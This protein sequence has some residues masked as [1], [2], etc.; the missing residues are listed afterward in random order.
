VKQK[1]VKLPAV[2]NPNSL[3]PLVLVFLL[4]AIPLLVGFWRFPKFLG[5]EGIYVS[6]AWWWTHFKEMGPYTYWY[7]HFPLGWLQIGLWQKLTGGP[8]AFG[9]SLFSGRLFMILVS[10]LSSVFLF[11]LIHNVTKSVFIAL[12][13]VV[14]FAF[15][16]LAVLFHRQVLLD[17]LAS[18]WLLVSLFVFLREPSK[19]KNVFLGSVFLA[20]AVLSKES[21]LFVVPPFLYM[22]HVLNSKVNRRYQTLLALVTTGFLLSLFPLLA[23]LKGEFLPGGEHVSFVETLF[24]QVKRGSGLLFWKEGSDLCQK[25]DF[26]LQID[27]WLIGAGFGALVLNLLFQ[28]KNKVVIGLALMSVFFTFFLIRGGTILDFYIIPLL[29]LLVLQ[30][31]FLIHLLTFEARVNGFI[32]KHPLSWFL[33]LAVLTMFWLKEGEFLYLENATAN[34]LQALESLQSIQDK[35][36]VIVAD[37]FVFLDLRIDKNNKVLF[38]NV[39][40]YSKTEY[41]QEIRDGKLQNDPNTVDYLLINSTMGDEIESGQLTFLKEVKGTMIKEQEYRFHSSSKNPL[42]KR[43]TYLAEDLVLYINPTLESETHRGFDSLIQE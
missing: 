26:W 19:G 33:P 21:L 11:K 38:P 1:Q 40:W 34:Q 27:P 10:S 16:P 37:N 25:L 28:H 29:P 23:F 18:F 36:A 2:A 20:A 13:G 30:I 7:D 9:F 6:Q 17:N 43:S 4:T 35:Q 3:L 41:D 5:D 14:V 31:C 22:V 15:S 32:K 12:F 24:F 39:E 8:F 42:L